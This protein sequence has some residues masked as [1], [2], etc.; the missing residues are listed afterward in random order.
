MHYRI[1]AEAVARSVGRFM[2][3]NELTS[4]LYFRERAARARW[5]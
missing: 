2:P 5:V 3:V 1:K 4:E